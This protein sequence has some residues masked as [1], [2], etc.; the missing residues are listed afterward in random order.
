ME[1]NRLYPLALSDAPDE[2][3][4]QR[5][6]EARLPARLLEDLVALIDVVRG[7]LAIRSSSLLEDSHYQP[8]AGIYSTYM[9]PYLEDSWSMVELLAKAVKSVY[10]SVFYSASK[11]Y[12]TATSNVIDQEKMAVIIQ[13]VVGEQHKDN[14]FMPSFSGVARSLNYYPLNNETPEDGVAEIAVGLGKYIVDGG[15]GLRFSPRHPRKVLQTS[16]LDLALR[17]TQTYLYALDTVNTTHDFKV[18]D[19]FN[20]VKRPVQDFAGS[21]ALRY[22]VSTYDAADG[23]LR[24]SDTGRGRRVV[25]FANVLRDGVFP[26]AGAVDF[27]LTAGASAMERPVEIEFAGIIDRDGKSK[28]RIYWLQ[29]RPIIDKKDYVDDAILNIDGHNL[30]LRSN[31]ALGHGNIDNVRSV[32]YV[33]PDKFNSSSTHAIADEIQ[34]INANFSNN[35]QHYVLVGPGRWGSSDPALGVPVKWPDISAARVI[36][37]SALPGYRIEPSQGT[38]FFHNLTSFGVAY[39]TI[40]PTTE[41]GICDTAYLDSLPATY[42]SEFVRVVNFEKPLSIAVNGMKGSGVVCK[43][44]I[45][46][47]VNSSSRPEN[48]TSN[49]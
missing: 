37:E 17:D 1:S 22:M 30:I 15:T 21:D 12:M 38:H 31:T 35:D 40:D 41:Q 8:F 36:A 6:I 16:T 23:M 29:M 4:L 27:M 47:P 10:A 13:E 49:S 33:R 3:I 42:E 18:D 26:L 20:I 11:V 7:P 28:G 9:I 19:G 44:E 34:K 48:I 46:S 25:T 14:C 39:F 45:I 2:E 5:F 32:V 24:D 43:P